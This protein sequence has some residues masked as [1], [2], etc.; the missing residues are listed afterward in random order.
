MNQI[1]DTQLLE[2]D[3]HGSQVGPEKQKYP[4][5]ARSTYKT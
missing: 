4:V 1:I 3:D 5:K 2:L